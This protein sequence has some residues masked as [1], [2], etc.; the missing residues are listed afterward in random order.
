MNLFTNVKWEYF[1]SKSHK[2]GANDPSENI[3]HI[4]IHLFQEIISFFQMRSG[5]SLFNIYK[6]ITLGFETFDIYCW[7]EPYLRDYSLDLCL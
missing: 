4:Y 6:K 3:F 2:F 7:H 1:A 5:M